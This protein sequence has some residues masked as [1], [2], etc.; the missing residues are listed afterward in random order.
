ME[1]VLS[2]TR[3]RGLFRLGPRKWPSDWPA[4][5][6]FHPCVESSPDDEGSLRIDDGSVR[7]RP[8]S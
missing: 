6:R 8:D 2:R 3:I 7:N 4:V 5:L 1:T